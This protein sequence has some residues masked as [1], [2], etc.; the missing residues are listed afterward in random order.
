MVTMLDQLTNECSSS[1]HGTENGKNAGYV[2]YDDTAEKRYERTYRR[3][4]YRNAILRA[5]VSFFSG[6]ILMSFFQ[7]FGLGAAVFGALLLVCGGCFVR[8]I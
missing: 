1:E 2:L 6:M 5:L 8:C 4:C 3:R 7:A